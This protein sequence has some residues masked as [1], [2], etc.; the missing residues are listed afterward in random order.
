MP[1]SASS[2]RLSGLS[3]RRCSGS[4][5]RKSSASASS[6]TIARPAGA[7]LAAASAAKRR[8]AT[9]MRGCQYGPIASRALRRTALM[10]PAM[11][12]TPSVS[13]YAQP[14]STGSTARPASSSRRRIRS[15]SS[16]AA[17]GSCSARTSS[18]QLA[19]ASERRI[20]GRTPASSAAAEHAPKSGRL[21]GGG[22]SA[23]GPRMSSG[24]ERRAARRENAWMFRQAIMGTYVLHEHTFSCQPLLL[25]IDVRRATR[26][27]ISGIAR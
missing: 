15:H 11:R 23:T 12:S 5:S 25:F 4:G 19:S 10:P 13:K 7:T 2:S 24:R 14:G 20:P 21:P 3:G 18:G 8:P 17:A 16:S 22:A 26:R 27:R 9:P 1:S 6:T